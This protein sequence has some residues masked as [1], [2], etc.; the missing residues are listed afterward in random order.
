MGE[1]VKKNAKFVV[2]FDGTAT[3]DVEKSIGDVPHTPVDSMQ[4]ALEAAQSRATLGDA[5]LLSPGTAS[6]G[7]FKNEF[8]RGEQFEK[9]VADLMKKSGKGEIKSSPK[10]MKKSVVLPKIVAGLLA[11]GGGSFV[12]TSKKPSEMNPTNEELKPDA[13]SNTV[14]SPEKAF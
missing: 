8:D 6:F 2:L 11:L 13:S 3:D 9:I 5:I 7:I 1:V 12:G 10:A 14:V 4:K